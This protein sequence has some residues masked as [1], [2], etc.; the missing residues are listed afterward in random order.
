MQYT[1][2]GNV[3]TI[4]ESE[5]MLATIIPESPYALVVDDDEAILSVVML[6]LET[7]GYTGLGFSDST[8]V[9]PFL[10]QVETQHLPH[11]IL[12]DL[13]MP[14]CQAMKLPLLSRNTHVLASIPIIIMTADNRVKSASTVP[15]ATDRAV[16]YFQ[17]ITFDKIGTL[18]VPT[19]GIDSTLSSGPSEFASHLGSI[20]EEST[21]SGRLY[22][23]NRCANLG[24]PGVEILS[25]IASRNYSIPVALFAFCSP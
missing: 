6:L 7:E 12:L 8:K 25:C 14:L 4:I 1:S 16:N 13:M 23:R 9:I 20:V 2:I 10:E 11:V 21:V 15:G 17:C 24:K 22:T 3:A 5:N 19:N 18:P